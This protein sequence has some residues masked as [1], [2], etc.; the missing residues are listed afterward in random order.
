MTRLLLLTA[1]LAASGCDPTATAFCEAR[2]ECGAYPD[3]DTCLQELR[4]ARDENSRCETEYYT[5]LDCQMGIEFTCADDFHALA[6]KS[7]FVPECELGMCLS[8]GASWRETSPDACTSDERIDP[9]GRWQ[10][11]LTMYDPA[12]CGW[13]DSS[14]PILVR[15]SA[16]QFQLTKLDGSPVTGTVTAQGRFAML[17]ATIRDGTNTLTV[18]ATAYRPPETTSARWIEGSA[19]FV[20]NGCT[21]SATLDGEVFPLPP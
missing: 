14:V 2:V 13:S 12:S 8:V 1:L 4:T 15:E 11:S 9:T 5:L 16:G 3:S 7:C 20:R 6:L 19:S 18:S 10:I 21:G 17:N